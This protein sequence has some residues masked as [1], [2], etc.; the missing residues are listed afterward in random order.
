MLIFGWDGDTLTARILREVVGDAPPDVL[1]RAVGSTPALPQ[2]P[3]ATGGLPLAFG[4]P[5]AVA[6]G[7]AVVDPRERPPRG[8]T[9][10][11]EPQDRIPVTLAPGAQAV[12]VALPLVPV[13]YR[14]IV[15]YLGL[16]T[17]RAADT[18]IQTRRNFAPALPYTG[19]VG[20]VGGLQDPTRVFVELAPGE[21]FDVLATNTG[22]VNLDAAARVIAWYWPES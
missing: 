18:L 1:A 5:G 16:T 21:V 7:A 19:A 15:R 4:A 6:P 9:Y 8:C 17:T 11:D 20:A 10:Y 14:G 13:G 2:V 12:L 3:G 22:A